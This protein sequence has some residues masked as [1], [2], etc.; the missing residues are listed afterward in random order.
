MLVFPV[1]MVHRP[2]V[3][4]H[5]IGIAYVCLTTKD[6][7]SFIITFK[8]HVKTKLVTIFN[9][10]WARWVVRGSNAVHVEALHEL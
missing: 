6:T 5:I 4:F 8:N 10:F 2:S 3:F 1:R 9:E 7:V